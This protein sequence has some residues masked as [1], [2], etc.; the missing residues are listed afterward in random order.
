MSD[1]LHRHPAL[2][3]AFA[4][5]QLRLVGPPGLALLVDADTVAILALC[6]GTRDLEA[7]ARDLQACLLY[8]SPS[9]RD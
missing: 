8:T 1:P 6:D 5:S 2:G 3:L 7:L 4:G 9:P